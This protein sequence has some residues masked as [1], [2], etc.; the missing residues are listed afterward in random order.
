MTAPPFLEE[1]AALLERTPRTIE[2]LL[3]GLPLSWLDTPDSAGGWTPR[4]VVG[5]LISA[6]L[7][8]WIPRI[9]LIISD[10]SSR[11]FEGFDRF[12]HVHRDAGAPLSALIDRFSDLRRQNLARLRE[13]VRE[14]ADLDRRGR[15]PQRGEVTLRE[16]LAAWSVHDL[17]H[18]QQIYAALAGSRDAAVGPFKAFLGILTRRDTAMPTK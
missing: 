5:H 2:A 8:N 11:P 4:D 3:G 14:E 15:H 16:L 13:L 17:D 10:G 7:S 9:E 12:A 1:T 6:E 18:V